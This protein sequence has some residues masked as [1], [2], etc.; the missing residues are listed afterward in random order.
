ML[1]VAPRLYRRLV[2]PEGEREQLLVVDQALEA[3]DRQEAVDLLELGLQGSRDVEIGLLAAV[4]GPDF[5]DHCD[6]RLLLS[7]VRCPHRANRGSQAIVADS[8]CS[9]V[10]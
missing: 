1:D 9:L 7:S 5:E 4:S 10:R 8:F 2:A 6:H 3:L